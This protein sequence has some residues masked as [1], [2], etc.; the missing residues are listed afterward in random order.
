LSILDG[1]TGRKSY[2]KTYYISKYFESNWAEAK[3][4]C[5]AFDLELA[6]FETLH[7]AESFFK[8]QA[9]A[10]P[11]PPY[12]WYLPYNNYAHIDGM[13]TI[14]GS[15]SDWY[16]TNSGIKIPYTMSWAFEQPNNAH[17]G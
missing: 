17:G 7:E 6:T 10:D 5:K 12:S 16:W 3:G 8:T 4:I 15:S 2:K 1:R 9:E 11:F 14:L 13:T